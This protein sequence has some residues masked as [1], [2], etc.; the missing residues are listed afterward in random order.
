MSVPV[1]KLTVCHLRKKSEFGGDVEE[2]VQTRK[3]RHEEHSRGKHYR[4]KQKVSEEN[5]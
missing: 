5:K 2:N 3:R 4:R 1:C